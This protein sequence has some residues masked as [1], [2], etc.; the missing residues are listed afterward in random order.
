VLRVCVEGF[1]AAASLDDGKMA[2]LRCV[3]LPPFLRPCLPLAF[4]SL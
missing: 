3:S 1:R 2:R 4:S